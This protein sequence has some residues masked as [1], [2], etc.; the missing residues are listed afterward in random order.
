VEEE[1]Q[2]VKKS[3]SIVKKG[4]KSAAKSKD[5]KMVQGKSGV[6]KLKQTEEKK[7]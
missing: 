1:L 5:S 4:S 3:K 2:E 6:K 7:A